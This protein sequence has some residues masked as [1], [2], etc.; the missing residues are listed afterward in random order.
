[1]TEANT[2]SSVFPLTPAIGKSTQ[3]QREDDL[4][5]T[6]MMGLRLTAEGLD[7]RVFMGR[8]GRDFVDMFPEGVERFMA[9]GL[10]EVTDERVHLTDAGRLLSNM[11]IREFV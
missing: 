4:Y 7:R 2:T 6:I 8:F 11:V 1:L 9:N 5:E 10:L 3:V